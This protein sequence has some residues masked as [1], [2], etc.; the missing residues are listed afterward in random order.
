MFR[1]RL[2]VQGIQ[3]SMSRKGDCWDNAV[4]ESF[5]GS[6]KQERVHWRNYQARYEAQQ[7]ILQY[8]SIFYNGRRLHSYL[9]YMSPN[10]YEK[11][12]LERKKAA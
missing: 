12:L 8:I 5:F 6:L 1:R 7:D 4:V 10:N 11:Q 9:G 3:G 2:K